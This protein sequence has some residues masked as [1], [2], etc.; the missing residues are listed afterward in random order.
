MLSLSGTAARPRLR[1]LGRAA[2]RLRT[3]Q[4]PGTAERAR[5]RARLARLAL[6]DRHRNGHDADLRQRPGA[7][8]DARRAERRHQ[9]AGAIDRRR[10]ALRPRQSGSSPRKLRCRWCSIVG[11]GLFM[12]TFS[13]LAHVRLGFEP[14][15]LMIVS[16]AAKRS[17]P[18][19][20]QQGGRGAPG[21]AARRRGR[22]RRR[23]AALQ[24]I[25]PLTNSEWD[26]L[27]QNPRGPVAAGKRARRLHERSES[28]ILR[29][30]WDAAFLPAVISRRRTRSRRRAS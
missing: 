12:R 6:H 29:H 20:R 18:S 28:R 10:I 1:A 7:A 24:N 17:A 30:V 21:A 15:P 2:A 13:T 9:G 8:L 3:L 16:A 27:I 4:G 22:A 5:R 26:T 14:D 11:A 19:I 23:V 25:T